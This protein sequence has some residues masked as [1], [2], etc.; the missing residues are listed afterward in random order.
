M[1]AESSIIDA[2][3][4]E[5]ASVT[6]AIQDDRV[7]PK[8]GWRFYGTFGSLC[9]VNL[10]CALDATIL[11]NALQVCVSQSIGLLIQWLIIEL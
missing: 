9:L 3:S 11:A 4:I 8:R 5:K 10:V 7:Q 6:S 1:T 2:P